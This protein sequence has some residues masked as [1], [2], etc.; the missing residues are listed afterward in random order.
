MITFKGKTRCD[1]KRIGNLIILINHEDLNQYRGKE[2]SY[3]LT[4]GPVSDLSDKADR[5]TVAYKGYSEATRKHLFEVTSC[6]SK[7]TYLIDLEVGCGCKHGGGQGI[8][9][10][11][12]CSH[13]LAVFR[14]IGTQDPKII[15]K[16]VRR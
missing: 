16:H 13:D 8:A 7:E 15:S 10:G 4:V 2:L 6:E 3:T 14:F 12:M 5:H 11:N 9:N 1:G